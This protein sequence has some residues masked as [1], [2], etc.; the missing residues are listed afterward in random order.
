MEKSI[1]E[2]LKNKYTTYLEWYEPRPGLDEI[3]DKID[4][5]ILLKATV[6]DCIN[7]QRSLT[8]LYE[9]KNLVLDEKEYLL[10]FIACNCA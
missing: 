7:Y 9:K 6:S 8:K 1:E 5:H 3:G 4:V 2:L 10:D